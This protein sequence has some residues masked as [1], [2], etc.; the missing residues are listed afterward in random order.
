MSERDDSAWWPLEFRM[1]VARASLPTGQFS[2]EAY[3]DGRYAIRD[4][5]SHGIRTR[6]MTVNSLLDVR[7]RLAE[8]A[9]PEL[10]EDDS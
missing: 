1:G 5:K 4:L 6:P 8:L 3:R 7:C 2:V 10:Q 9:Y